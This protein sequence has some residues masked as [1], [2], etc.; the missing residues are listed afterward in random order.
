MER[1]GEKEE[2]KNK[3]REMEDKVRELQM[4]AS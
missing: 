4:G 2:L 1:G 3:L